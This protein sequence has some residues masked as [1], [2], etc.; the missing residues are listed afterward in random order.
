MAMDKLLESKKVF[1]LGSG[2]SRALYS[3]MPTLSDLTSKIDLDMTRDESEENKEFAGYYLNKVPGRIKENAEHLLSFLWMNMPW[4]RPEMVSI[5][6]GLFQFLSRKFRENLQFSAVHRIQEL[7]NPQGIQRLFD[8]IHAF[9]IPVISFNYDNI[10]EDLFCHFE[11]RLEWDFPSWSNQEAQVLVERGKNDSCEI[12]WEKSLHQEDKEYLE[13]RFK[14]PNLNFSESLA[15]K[16]K[17]RTLLRQKF[18][19]GNWEVSKLYRL[20]ESLD[21][22]LF[23]LAPLDIFQMP[24]VQADVREGHFHPRTSYDHAHLLKLHGSINWHYSGEMGAVYEQIYYAFG[25]VGDLTPFII[26]PILDKN[27]FYTHSSLRKM[28]VD[29]SEYIRNAEEIYIIGYSLP[30]TDLPVNF[31]LQENLRPRTTVYIVNRP[32]SEEEKD[33]LISRYTRVLPSDVVLNADYC[34]D[35]E[36][37]LKKFID[38]KVSL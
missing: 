18:Y 15:E 28:W 16:G 6:K 17:L 38:E 2:F 36:D 31:F 8:E 24:L 33:Q 14:T 5:E 9:R 26:P 30:E 12:K 21:P 3:K 25:N 23:K 1:I 4:K 22:N 19:Q 37:P 11:K 35:N 34:L 32:S 7:T 20:E 27:S 13:I 10:F 29:A